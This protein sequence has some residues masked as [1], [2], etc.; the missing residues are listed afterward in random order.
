MK[1]WRKAWTVGVLVAVLGLGA[2]SATAL[3]RSDAWI[4]DLV[5]SFRPH[6][7]A[8]ALALLPLGLTVRGGWRSACLAIVVACLAING[9]TIASA[10]RAA[11]T[12]Q[13][14]RGGIRLQVVTIN[15]LWSNGQHQRLR[16]WLRSEAPD[17]V[18]T[19]E[20][21]PRWAAML[22]GLDGLFP[23]RRLPGPADDL[24]VLSRHPFDMAAEVGIRAHGTLAKARLS[25]GRRR[26]DLMA[27][28][29]SVPASPAWRIARDEMF[30]DIAG[31]A[32]RTRYPL[33]VAG[34]FNATP[35]NRSMRRLVRESPL[36][37]APGFW[38]PTWTAYVPLW[39][40]IPLDHVLAAGECRVVARRI[41][42]DIGSDHRP[43]LA[44]VDCL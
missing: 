25:V 41:G 10:V 13:E 27:L 32:R 26:I 7:L 35:W 39:M 24:A 15:L 34:D 30:E 16:D 40:G 4:A 18:V 8:G 12:P 22:A 5:E 43:V 29:A 17:I 21:T 36:R 31:F 2:S 33:I 42:P 1:L 9:A 20:T 3:F 11:T 38:R 6:L 44:T 28:H 23:H 37:H 14:A 19:Q